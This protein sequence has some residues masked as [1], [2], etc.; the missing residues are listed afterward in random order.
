MFLNLAAGMVPSS[1]EVN[2]TCQLGLR[3]SV[4]SVSFVFFYNIT[5]SIIH[6]A[7]RD[8]SIG[9]LMISAACIRIYEYYVERTIEFIVHKILLLRPKEATLK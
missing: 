1:S 9:S 2:N 5:Y 4:A 7:F 6:F 3:G 8:Y